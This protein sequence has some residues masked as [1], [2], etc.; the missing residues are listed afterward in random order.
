MESRRQVS[1]PVIVV[2]ALLIRTNNEGGVSAAGQQSG[3]TDE[4]TLY[5]DRIALGNIGGDPLYD[6]GRQMGHC[7]HGA[8]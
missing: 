4:H 3:Q 5:H 7:T 1:T 8:S 2:R 6:E